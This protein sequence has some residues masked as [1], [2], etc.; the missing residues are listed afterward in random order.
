[1]TK[2]RHRSTARAATRNPDRTRGRILAAALAEFAACGFSGAR[3]DT[4]AR[5]A[6]INKR[7]LYHYFGDKAHLFRSVLHQKISERRAWGA[8]LSSDPADRL[9]F[10]FK[11]AC[12]DG[13]WIRLLEWEALQNPKQKVIDENE[14]MSIA[15][16]W[17]E[18][19]RERQSQGQLSDE[20]NPRHL[21]L[22]M[23]SLTMFP[24]AFPQMTRFIAGCS[25][26]D[27]KFQQ[28]YSDFLKKFADA[29]RPKQ[30]ASIKINFVK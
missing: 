20:F 6:G 23:Q 24:A 13:D 17:I 21:A 26:N 18:R 22:A 25:A 2:K 12:D 5:R 9:P 10:W 27:A 29:F 7:M 8:T 30:A 1:M 28:E 16:D 14:R 19:L 3:V 15:C 11:M 4:I